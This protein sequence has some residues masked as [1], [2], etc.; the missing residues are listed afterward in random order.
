MTT[1]IQQMAQS[2]HQMLEMTNIT[3]NALQVT[4][5]NS[6]NIVTSMQEQSASTEEMLSITVELNDVIEHLTQQIRH[7]KL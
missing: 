3:V 4:N 5:D 1:T 7:F 6:Q 2:S